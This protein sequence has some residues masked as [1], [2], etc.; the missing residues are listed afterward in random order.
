MGDTTKQLTINYTP[1]AKLGVTST[2]CSGDS[3]LITDT[4]SISSGTITSWHYNFGDGSSITRTTIKRSTEKV[5]RIQLKCR[6]H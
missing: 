1:I 5:G 4:S 3:V 2:S 6:L